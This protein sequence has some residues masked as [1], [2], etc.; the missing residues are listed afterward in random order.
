VNFFDYDRKKSGF[1]K[2]AF[3]TV[4]EAGR[5]LKATGQRDACPHPAKKS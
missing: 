3:D 2:P 4:T 5:C 1:K